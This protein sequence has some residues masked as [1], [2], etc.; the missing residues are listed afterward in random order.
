VPTPALIARQMG[1]SVYAYM[2]IF[3]A[4]KGMEFAKRI[5][6]KGFHSTIR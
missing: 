5:S 2:C 1:S 6:F 4:K 3:K